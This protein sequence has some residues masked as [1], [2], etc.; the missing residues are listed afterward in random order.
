MI[1]GDFGDSLTILPI[2]YQYFSHPRAIPGPRS[3]RCCCHT[4]RAAARKSC[5]EPKALRDTSGRIRLVRRGK[6][7]ENDI[8]I[9]N[10]HL[11]LG[12]MAFLKLN[13]VELLL[14][15]CVLVSGQNNPRNIAICWRY[16]MEGGLIHQSS[17]FIGN[18]RGFSWQYTLILSG[19]TFNPW[20][21][22]GIAF[23]GL[24]WVCPFY[25]DWSTIQN[26]IESCTPFRPLS[27]SSKRGKPSL[28]DD[29]QTRNSCWWWWMVMAMIMMTV[30]TYNQLPWSSMIYAMLRLCGAP[31]NPEI[32]TLRFVTWQLH[33]KYIAFTLHVVGLQYSTLHKITLAYCT[34]HYIT[35]HWLTVQYIT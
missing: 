26:G 31:E 7:W 3:P 16:I 19:N 22:G 1:L 30:R 11:G 25:W 32:N 17:D 10:H 5:P 18:K 23:E 35:V 28:H 13:S 8:G 21:W 15:Y 9:E 29:F 34:V 33:G 12:R 14:N 27:G 24:T 4:P 20:F 2:I 6:R